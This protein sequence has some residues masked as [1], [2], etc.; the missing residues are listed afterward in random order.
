M[1]NYRI[2]T[3]CDMGSVQSVSEQKQVP[4]RLVL[5]APGAKQVLASRTGYFETGSDVLQFRDD[6]QLRL[7]FAGDVDRDGRLDLLLDMSDHY[8]VSRLTLWLSTEAAKG[9]VVGEAAAFESVGC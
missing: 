1:P 6:G 4:C 2:E 8:N 3:H 5:H 9:D 7:L